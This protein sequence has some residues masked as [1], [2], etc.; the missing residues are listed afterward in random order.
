MSRWIR[1]YLCTSRGHRRCKPHGKYV[2]LYS[3]AA[4]QVITYIREGQTSFMHTLS[5]PRRTGTMRS[6][7]A[8]RK[9]KSYETRRARVLS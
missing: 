8:P 5:E 2:M 3:P 7:N 6:R 9:R 1:F 4:R